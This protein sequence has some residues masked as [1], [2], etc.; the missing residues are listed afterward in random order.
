MGARKMTITKL[1][2][3]VPMGSLVVVYAPVA[4]IANEVSLR[5]MARRGE[6]YDI[7]SFVDGEDRLAVIVY[8]REQWDIVD[9]N[10]LL[11]EQHRWQKIDNVWRA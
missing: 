9:A 8:R 6:C 3:S 11:Q 5:N 2:D 10:L 1:L 4:E 7:V